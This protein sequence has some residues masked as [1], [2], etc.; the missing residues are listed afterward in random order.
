M[1]NKNIYFAASI[2]GGRAMQIDYAQQIGFLNT[3]GTVLTE[4]IAS[5]ALTERG[6]ELPS[7]T[8]YA[9]DIAMINLAAVVVA[10]VT[11]PSLGVGFEIC[12]ALEHKKPVICMCRL[13]YKDRLSA[14]IGGCPGVIMCYYENQADFELQLAPLL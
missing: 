13:D 6:D 14:M 4:H 3:I 11:V 8:I 1:N 9:R 12:Y 2:R 5:A 7:D 10:E